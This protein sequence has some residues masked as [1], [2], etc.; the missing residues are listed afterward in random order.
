MDILVTCSYNWNERAI[1]LQYSIVFAIS[2]IC[3]H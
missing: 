2:Q 1:H 3:G